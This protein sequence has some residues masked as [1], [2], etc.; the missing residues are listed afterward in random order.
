MRLNARPN[1]GVIR[2]RGNVSQDQLA[3]MTG[4]SV[5]TIWK[6]EN[7]HTSPRIHVAWAIVKALRAVQ[8]GIS[9]H[10][11]FPEPQR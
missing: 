7:G 10:D 5:P 4:L 11:V 3:A 9:F 8:P 6:A 1:I 2:T